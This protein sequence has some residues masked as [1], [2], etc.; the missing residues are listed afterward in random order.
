MLTLPSPSVLSRML[1]FYRGCWRLCLVNYTIRPIDLKY[2]FISFSYSI[3]DVSIILPQWIVIV[4][5]FLMSDQTY[6]CKCLYKWTFSFVVVVNK[7]NWSFIWHW[8][9]LELNCFFQ[10]SHINIK[11]HKSKNRFICVSLK[12]YWSDQSR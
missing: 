2:F 4:Y 5:A 1:D 6:V 9:H 12:V 7:K 3:L 10:F 11:T 8:K